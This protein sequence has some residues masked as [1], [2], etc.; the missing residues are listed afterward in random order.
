MA[1]A[2]KAAAGQE[3]ERQEEGQSPQSATGSLT[4]PAVPAPETAEAPRAVTEELPPSGSP[5]EE[6]LGTGVGTEPEEQHEE[7]EAEQELLAFR[8][9]NEE[10]LLPVNLVG[11]VLTPKEITSV[12]HVPEYILG[13]C[14]LRGAVL[15]IID[16]HQ[17]LGL[18]ESAHDERSRIIVVDLGPDDRVGLYVDRVR[19][20]IR[21]RPSTIGS[22]PETVEQGAGADFLRGIVRKDD[23]LYIILDVEKTVAA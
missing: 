22:V 15:P 3:P 17:R 16:L 8:L 9:G 19:G 4:A 10:Y 12:P 14:S 6:V 7:Q 5:V 21:I 11:E 1:R 2:G 13:V 23:R 18:A 20:V